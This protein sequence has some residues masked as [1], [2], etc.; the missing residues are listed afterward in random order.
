M[1]PATSRDRSSTVTPSSGPRADGLKEGILF[2][3]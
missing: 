2:L 1:L 3:L